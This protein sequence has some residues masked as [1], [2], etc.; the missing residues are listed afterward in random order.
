MSLPPLHLQPEPEYELRF[1]TK[2]EGHF[3]VQAYH[4]A[5]TALSGQSCT[6]SERMLW[7]CH[8]LVK[9]VPELKLTA[10]YKDLCGLLGR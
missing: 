2:A 6:P 7:A 4:T 10:A 9:K 1:V 3:S 5:R 8:E